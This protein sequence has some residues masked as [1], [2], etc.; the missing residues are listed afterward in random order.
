MEVGEVGRDAAAQ[1][2]GPCVD[3]ALGV[4]LAPLA[5]RIV[6]ALDQWEGA[7]QWVSG[8]KQA[9]QRQLFVHDMVARLRAADNA[10]AI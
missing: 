10:D 1:T 5:L 3:H 7:A 8:R 2:L 4:V 6:D 9:V